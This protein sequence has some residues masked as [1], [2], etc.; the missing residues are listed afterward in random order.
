MIDNDE[1]K[2]KTS[3]ANLDVK[4]SQ[5][6]IQIHFYNICIK[7]VN[8]FFIF[9]NLSLILFSI[10]NKIYKVKRAKKK[11]SRPMTGRLAVA[12]F[13]ERHPSPVQSNTGAVPPS[14]H[15]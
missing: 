1:I 15:T 7:D 14:N 10:I 2:S 8:I 4:T 5:N 11:A 12:K 3:T 6:L 13:C 9:I